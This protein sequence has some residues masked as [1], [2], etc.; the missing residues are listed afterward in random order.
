MAD[1]SGGERVPLYPETGTAATLMRGLRKRCPRC[2]EGDTFR[3][4]FSMRTSCPRCEWRF[5]KEEGG[6]LG[7]MVLNYLVAIGLW[8]VV[9]VVGLVLTVPDVPVLPLT[10]ASVTVLVVVPLT[11]Y[12]TSKTTWAAVE[13]LVLRSDPDYHSPEHRDPRARD[14]E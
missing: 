12:P 9:L 11:F 8:I 10:I 4:W 1:R 2:G 3:S 7:A 6:Y 13:Y 5:E 14:L